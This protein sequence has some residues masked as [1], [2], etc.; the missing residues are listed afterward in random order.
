M[1][2]K[3]TFLRSWTV[4]AIVVFLLC[5]R[6]AASDLRLVDAVKNREFQAVSALLKKHPDVNAREAD[7]ATALMWAAYWDNSETVNLLIKAGANVDLANQQGVTP[8]SL[9][10]QN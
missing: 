6:T 3:G 8:I 2:A 5:I 10:C 9:A 7:G 4:L 1:P